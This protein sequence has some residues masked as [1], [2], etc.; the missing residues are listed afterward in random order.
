[1]QNRLVCAPSGMRPIQLPAAPGRQG[2]LQLLVYQLGVRLLCTG[3][4]QEPVA[5]Q[6]LAKD[7]QDGQ[8]V[9]ADNVWAQA[10]PGQAGLPSAS[11]VT[12]APSGPVS[13][14]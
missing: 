6:Q 2:G 3:E 1:V 11:C 9:A 10:S 7:G 13:Q 5:V 4:Q 12:A 14:A 8:P